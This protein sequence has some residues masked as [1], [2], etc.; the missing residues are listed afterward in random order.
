M[1]NTKESLAKLGHTPGKLSIPIIK[2]P[3]KMRMG[4]WWCC[5]RGDLI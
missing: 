3:P 2:I 1:G 5:G 4:M